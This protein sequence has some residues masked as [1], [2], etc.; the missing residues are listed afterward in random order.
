MHTF[1]ERTQKT[2]THTPSHVS[3]SSQQEQRQQLQQ[4]GQQLEPL[5]RTDLSAIANVFGEDNCEDDTLVAVVCNKYGLEEWPHTRDS[6]SKPETW[7]LCLESSPVLR[8]C[9]VQVDGEELRKMFGVGQLIASDVSYTPE[10][11]VSHICL[12]V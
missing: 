1:Y 9:F 6:R 2:C 3:P 12:V 11:V 7:R 5:R 4:S 8:A 10:Q